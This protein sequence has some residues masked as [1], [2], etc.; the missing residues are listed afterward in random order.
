MKRLWS[1]FMII[2]LLT[3]LSACSDSPDTPIE[4]NENNMMINIKNNANFDFYGLETKILNHSQGMTNADGS[5][6]ENGEELRFEFL[7]ED[8]EL[9]GE[10]EME[11]FI[12]ADGNVEDD[13]DRIQLNK[14]VTLELV[15]NKELFFEIT[16]DSINEADLKR[17]K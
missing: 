15:N 8:F 6:I 12:L 4:P 7:K 1:L 5:I 3:F 2:L 9:D 17:I 13:V 10:V 14:K 16:G 11:T